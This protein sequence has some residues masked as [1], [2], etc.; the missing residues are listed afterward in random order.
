MHPN[1]W[2]TQ[3]WARHHRRLGQLEDEDNPTDFSGDGVPLISP[4]LVS[5]AMCD[6][7]PKNSLY[8]PKLMRSLAANVIETVVDKCLEDVKSDAVPDAHHMITQDYRIWDLL[9]VPEQS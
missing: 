3:I 7:D 2:A 5:D 8:R 1:S 4:G 9:T 6:I